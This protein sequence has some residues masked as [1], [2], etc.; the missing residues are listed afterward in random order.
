MKLEKEKFLKIEFGGELE[1]TIIAWDNNLEEQWLHGYASEEYRRAMQSAIW[2][3]A[4]WE[5]YRMAIKHFFGVEYHFT[6][7]DEYFGLCTE[8]ESDF[9]F[10]RERR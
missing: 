7:T 10:K 2:C 3:Q 8:D 1:S 5:V 9:L 4:Q 6:R